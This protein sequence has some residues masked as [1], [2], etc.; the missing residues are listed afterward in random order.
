[1]SSDRP[2]VKKA[3]RGADLV[4]PALALVFAVYF[5]ISIADLAWEAKANGV[6]IG[7][8]LLILVALQ[9]V[10]IGREVARG[11]ADLR[12]DPLWRPRDVLVKRIGMV[13][14]TV[15]FIAAMDR[16]GLTLAVWLAMTAALAVMGVRK[17]S[18]LL[19]L[20]LAVATAVYVMFVAVLDS[21]FPRGPIERLLA[22]LFG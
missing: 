14:I 6:L 13:L 12:T 11:E 15:V 17:R 1:M 4:I 3:P 22:A 10:R 18:I 19:W 8:I 20:P 2:S 5:F 21:A 16:L 9:L 7:I